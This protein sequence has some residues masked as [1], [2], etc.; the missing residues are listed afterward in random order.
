M[1]KE[2]KKE[3]D[4]KYYLINKEKILE[5]SRKFQIENKKSHQNCNMKWRQT[6]AGKL[7]GRK[8]HLKS[9]YKMTIEEFD[10]RLLNQKGLCAICEKLLSDTKYICIDH[11][12]ET[13]AVRGILCKP[14]NSAIGF[15]KDSPKL[16]EAAKMYIEKDGEL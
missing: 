14:C 6:E 8:G 1:L 7:A 9:K 5:R 16:L 15:L 4:K 11:N 10:K 13:G 2:V 3:Y 12:H